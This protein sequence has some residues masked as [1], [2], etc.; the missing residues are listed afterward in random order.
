MTRTST[1]L[2]A[3]RASTA[4][5]AH[6]ASGSARSFRVHGEVAEPLTLT[7]AELRARWPEHRAEVVFQ[8][9]QSGPRRH[10]FQG[11]LL[12]EVLTAAEPCFDPR[13][14][15]HRSRFLV[16]VGGGDG[17]HTVLSWAEIDA[18]FGAAPLLLATRIDGRDLDA[19]G[20]QLVVPT[21]HCGARYVSAVTG[22]W[23][24]ACGRDGAPPAAG[25]A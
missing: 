21:D 8:C 24:G 6:R 15:K 9:A 10:T 22:I 20:C 16:A 3:A 25:D 18:D 4:L 12:R 7:A 17:H 23:V 1:A 2:T 5:T 11:P 19:D 13:R 14:R